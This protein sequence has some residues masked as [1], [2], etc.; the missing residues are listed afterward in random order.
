MPA[1]EPCSGTQQALQF[2]VRLQLVQ[3]PESRDHALART[4]IFPAVLHDLQIGSRTGLLCAKEH[5]STS[6]CVTMILAHLNPFLKRVGNSAWHQDSGENPVLSP[7]AL[8]FTEPSQRGRSATVE[9]EY[10]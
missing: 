10:D 5:G 8:D 4:A 9:D 7:L 1:G 6:T 3:T 2:T